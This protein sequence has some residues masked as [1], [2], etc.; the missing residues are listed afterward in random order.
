MT[1]QTYSDKPTLEKWNE[2]VAAAASWRRSIARAARTTDAPPLTRG[3]QQKPPRTAWV[4]G[5]FCHEL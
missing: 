3:V 5:G 2:L 4:K 1:E